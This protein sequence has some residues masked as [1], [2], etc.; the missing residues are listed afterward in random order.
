[1]SEGNR[2]AATLALAYAPT[3]SAP[4]LSTARY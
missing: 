4:S 2:V 1:M 3:G